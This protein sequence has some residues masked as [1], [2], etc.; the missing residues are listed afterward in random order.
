M[1]LAR[2]ILCTAARTRES[3]NPKS[4]AA[5]DVGGSLQRFSREEPRL[6]S[7]GCHQCEVGSRVLE[8]ERVSD[9]EVVRV[10]GESP[11]KNIAFQ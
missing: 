2:H 8:V 9:P 6:L 4:R 5:R 1:I 11:W 3:R 7:I 10:G